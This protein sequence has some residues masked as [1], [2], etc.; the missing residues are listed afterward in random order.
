MKEKGATVL[1]LV[2]V[3]GI[4]ATLFGIVS[5]NVFN[6]VEKSSLHSS[7]TTLVSD[8]KSQQ[9][10]AMSQETSGLYFSQNSYTLFT[11]SENFVV[12]LGNNVE[13]SSILLPNNTLTFA[14]MTGEVIGYNDNMH[15]ITIKNTQNNETKTI[16]INKLGVLDT[17]E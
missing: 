14:K 16:N 1:E 15:E 10:K 4:F 3:I 8:I 7:I 11:G 13:F 2:T 9:I 12:P 17:L 5:V 6:A